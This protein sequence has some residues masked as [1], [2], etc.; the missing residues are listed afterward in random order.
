MLALAKHRIAAGAVT[1]KEYL[2]VCEGELTGAG[3]IAEPIGLKEGSR[4]VRACGAGQPAVTRFW[5]LD[6]REGHSLV[7]LRLET[8]RTHQI[9]VHMSAFGNPLAGDDLYGGS[10]EYINR[11]ALHCQL[12]KLECKAV[13]MRKTFHAAVPKD[14]LKAFPQLP[15]NT[16]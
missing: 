12:L 10:R 8:G 1:E 6:S 15:I 13:S 5:A 9:R 2:A 3:S 14:I 7:R 11:Q 16:N 4:I